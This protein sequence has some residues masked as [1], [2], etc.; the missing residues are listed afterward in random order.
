MPEFTDGTIYFHGGAPA[1][2]KLNIC[3]L[4]NTLRFI[5]K[6]GAEMIASNEDNIYKVRIDTVLFMRSGGLYYRMCPLWD[7]LGI[8]VMRDV[9]AV[10]AGKQ[11]A[12][13]TTS[14]TSSIREN[15]NV[16]ADGVSYNIEKSQE[17][18]FEAVETLY[19]YK[20]DDILVFNKRNLRKLFPESKDAIDSYFKGGGTVP[21][22]V[23][24]AQ[25]LLRSW[26]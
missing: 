16:Y 8:A 11:G 24:E 7:D 5:D 21:S 4:D 6:D 10:R 13:G 15:A 3:A 2:G 12:Y 23:P 25:E 1:K 26:K 19:L 20:G 18:P 22:T 17:A 9:R 14:Q